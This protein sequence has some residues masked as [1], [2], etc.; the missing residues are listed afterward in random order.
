MHFV[1]MR[2]QRRLPKFKCSKVHFFVGASWQKLN[3]QKCIFSPDYAGT[4]Q[5][6]PNC[7]VFCPNVFNVLLSVPKGSLKNGR[8]AQPVDI[9]RLFIHYILICLS[10]SLYIYIYINTNARFGGPRK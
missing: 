2:V 7:V 10:L 5:A 4:I 9:A 8:R 6:F 3:L 1:A